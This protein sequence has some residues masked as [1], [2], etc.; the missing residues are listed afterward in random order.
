MD[1]DS[2]L[3]G[4]REEVAVRLVAADAEKELEDDIEGLTDGDVADEGVIE[5]LKDCVGRMKETVGEGVV[6]IA[7][8]LGNSLGE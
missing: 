8:G 7:K 5:G 2:D 3:E 6:D 4:L 1:P